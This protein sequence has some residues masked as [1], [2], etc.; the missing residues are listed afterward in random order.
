M[1]DSTASI[2]VVDAKVNSTSDILKGLASQVKQN[3]GVA[4]TPNKIERV[5]PPS[6]PAMDTYPETTQIILMSLNR[7]EAARFQFDMTFDEERDLIRRTLGYEAGPGAAATRP[8]K[9]D[10]PVTGGTGVDPTVDEQ[11]FEASLAVKSAAAQAEVFTPKVSKTVADT[12]WKCPDHG[13]FVAKT[14]RAGAEYRECPVC[15]EFEL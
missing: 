7:I 8:N 14:N 10:R 13:K 2:T 5:A 6:G 12:G 1:A 11:A 9:T 4:L 3:K 15:D